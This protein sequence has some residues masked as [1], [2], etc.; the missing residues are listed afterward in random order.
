MRE[1]WL[2]AQHTYGERVRTRSFLFTTFGLPLLMVAVMV[3]FFLIIMSG[4]DDRPLGYVDRAGLLDPKVSQRLNATN[5]RTVEMQAFDTEDAAQEALKAE[6][7]QAYY[8]VPED[9]LETQDLRLY[10]WDEE[11]AVTIL[12]NF[13]RFLRA[14][15]I[16]MQPQEVAATLTEGIDLTVR[17]ADGSKSFSSG[18]ILSFLLPFL[19][20]TSFFFSINN[21]GNYMFYAIMEEKVSRTIEILVTSISPLQLMGGKALGLVAVS[22]TQLA[23]WLGTPTILALVAGHFIPQSSFVAIPWRILLVALLYF[24]PT[25]A[26]MASLMSA[27][28]AV[29][30]EKR[31]AYLIKVFINMLSS[32]PIFFVILVFADPDSPFLVFLSLFPTTAFTTIMLRW[33]LTSIPLWQLICSW[34]LLI[35]VTG[36]SL[37]MAARVFRVGMLRYGQRLKLPRALTDLFGSERAA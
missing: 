16:A 4:I 22:L 3:V 9:Y 31:Q 35:L 12:F 18:N 20:A 11:P 30:G 5:T 26:L 19:L 1:L 24:L 6:K 23:I 32:V 2:V 7:I 27:I 10:Y 28:G 21:S 37:W 13:N 25:F 33:S 36:G 34:L 15:L 8:V 17:S 29:F 14:S